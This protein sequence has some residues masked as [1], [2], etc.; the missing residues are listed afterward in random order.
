MRP[1]VSYDASGVKTCQI[2]AQTCDVTAV[3]CNSAATESCG[4]P[5]HF[6]GGEGSFRALCS[7]SYRKSGVKPVK[8]QLLSAIQ[9]DRKQRPALA[10]CRAG[11]GYVRMPT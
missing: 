3:Q 1:H 8:L 7:I 5:W 11:Q 2:T 4:R 6:A 9:R 10:F